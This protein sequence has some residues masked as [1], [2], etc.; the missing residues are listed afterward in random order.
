MARIPQRFDWVDCLAQR[1]GVVVSDVAKRGTWA[2]N[3]RCL[4]RLDF[5]DGIRETASDMLSSS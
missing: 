3:D 2:G 1:C 5:A 4:G